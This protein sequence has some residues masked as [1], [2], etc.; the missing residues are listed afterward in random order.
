VKGEPPAGDDV[1]D[2]AIPDVV[3]GENLE[4]TSHKS[5]RAA[6]FSVDAN[7]VES[8]WFTD[9]TRISGLY[10]DYFLG[11]SPDAQFSSSGRESPM[12]I[13]D[14][15]HHVIGVVMPLR[16]TDPPQAVKEIIRSCKAQ[17]EMAAATAEMKQRQEVEARNNQGKEP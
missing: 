12:M 6:G 1:S 4:L 15:S 5:V 3:F 13:T 9:G 8:I 14:S 11:F 16:I 10:Y 7:G 17:Q 2:S